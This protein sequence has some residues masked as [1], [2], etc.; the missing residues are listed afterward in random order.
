VSQESGLVANPLQNPVVVV[1]GITATELDD[2]YPMRTERLWDM[3]FERAYERIALHPDDLRYEARE[4]ARVVTGRTFTVYDD[5]VRSLRHELSPREDRPTPVFTFPYDWRM[6]IRTAAGHLADFIDEVRGRTLLLKHYA[7]AEDLRVDLVGHSM[8][9]LLIVEY[10]A[11]AG[12]DAGVGKVATLGT[13]YLGAV[14]AVVKIATGMSLLTGTQP[15]EREREAARVTPSIYQ[16]LPS[17][18]G[19][20]R[21]SPGGQTVDLFDADNM[22]ESVVSSLTEFVRLYSGTTPAPRREAR[23][24]ELLDRLLEGGRAHRRTVADFDPEA[25]GLEPEDWLAVVGAGERTRVALTV[26]RER[27]GR[28]FEFSDHDLADDVPGRRT[29]DGT[30]PL[31]GALPPFLPEG[32]V[33]C[34]TRDDLNFWEIGDRIL[35]RIAGFHGML[36][37]VNLVARLVTRHLRPSF[38][39]EAWG[40][41]VPGVEEWNPPISGL[42]AAERRWGVTPL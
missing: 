33:V 13:P 24:R 20:A 38:R 15:R 34:V 5:L 25:A 1:P 39:G 6:D 7:G 16:M 4:P 12:A 9:G 18:D 31:A 26:R 8:G 3:L 17:Y 32:Q 28:R 14:E 35:T 30:V 29:G 23:A 42:A 2:E 10:L 40:R 27:R 22:Q 21:V 41:R 19:A 11:T 36:P 37:K